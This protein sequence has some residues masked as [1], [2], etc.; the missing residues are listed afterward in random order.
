MAHA[1]NYVVYFWVVII[2]YYYFSAYSY[3]F[4]MNQM[5]T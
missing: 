2:A 1:M 4:E 3:F 5:Q